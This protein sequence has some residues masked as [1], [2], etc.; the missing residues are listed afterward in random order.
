M[1]FHLT[2][3]QTAIQDAVR[4]TLADVWGMERLHRFAD[5]DA[6]FDPQSWAAL[7]ALGVGGLALREADG[8]AGLGLLDAALV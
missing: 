8:G 4:G 7:M 5:G 6:D 1:R 3:E 2:E